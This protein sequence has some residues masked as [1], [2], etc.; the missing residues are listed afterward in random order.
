[1]LRREG[2]PSNAAVHR[3]DQE[4]TT[5]NGNASEELDGDA[6]G[7][8]VRASANPSSLNRSVKLIDW[9]L[10]FYRPHEI[11]H[12]TVMPCYDKKLEASRG[13][14]YNEVYSTRDVDCVITT[15]ELELLMREKGWDLSTP[16][17]SELVDTQ[18]P[19]VPLPLPLHPT[20]PD[21]VSDA[22]LP[23]LM[24]HPG[25]SS[26]SYL[27]SI[28]EHLRTTSTVP[29]E[30]STKQIRNADYEEYVLRTK[31]G[32][33][34][35][36]GEVVFK[37]ARCYGFRNLQNVVRKVGKETGIRV[38]VGAA[39]RLGGRGGAVSRMGR[40]AAVGETR[41]YDY[42]EVMACPGG[43]VNGGG[44]LKPPR[45][46]PTD[47]DAEGFSRSWGD[48]G[49]ALDGEKTEA[50]SAKWGNKEWTK[51]VEDAYW[52]D[53]T[54]PSAR[55]SQQMIDGNSALPTSRETDVPA[56]R[57]PD[58]QEQMMT[59]AT[60]LVKDILGDICLTDEGLGDVDLEEEKELCR[61][62]LFRT[63]YRA[64]ESEVIGLAV[65]W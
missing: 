28:I 53:W 20:R 58:L 18:V 47:T 27:Q 50:L 7:K 33:A 32:K 59:V 56:G 5:S 16:V 6:M 30:L 42:V 8:T 57:V 2:A 36:E 48:N 38:G 21:S 26:G 31:G 54:S 64:V 10:H 23:E 40:K 61:K 55:S 17:P 14:F 13:D 11:Y 12:V 41:G 49:V 25:S 52:N 51:K 43:C 63:Q 1:M 45:S 62:K 15:G 29:L 44:Q 46:L 37:G 24:A 4:P 65:K 3:S 19:Q 35:A 34:G 22:N 9:I 60:R 39:G